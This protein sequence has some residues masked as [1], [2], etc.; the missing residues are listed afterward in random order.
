MPAARVGGRAQRLEE[1]LVFATPAPFLF[2][3]ER[4]HDRMARGMEVL[5]GVLV[6]RLVA[7][8]HVTTLQADA[9]VHPARASPQAVLAAE[10]AGLDIP[11][12]PRGQMGI[13]IPLALRYFQDR[14]RHLSP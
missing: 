7:A 4:A 3:L 1:L 10:G 13:M 6:G 8:A 11:Y 12:V 5:G 14:V 2:R 9:Q